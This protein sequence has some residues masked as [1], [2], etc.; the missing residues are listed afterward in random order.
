MMEKHPHKSCWMGTK[1]IKAN[2]KKLMGEKIDASEKKE[3]TY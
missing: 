2:L 1:P 3:K